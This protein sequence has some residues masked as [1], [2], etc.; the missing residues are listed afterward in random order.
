MR[1]IFFKEEQ[2]INQLWIWAVLIVSMGAMIVPTAIGFYKQFYL[3][4]P[5]GTNPTGDEALLWIGGLELVFAIG[6]I[7]L[8]IKMKLVTVVKE[9]GFYYRY[10][11]L[12]LK[13]KRI[14]KE[15]IER[16]EIRKYKPILEY[17]GWGVRLGS[18]KAGR[19][20]NVKGNIGLQ[21]ELKNGRKILFG[22]QRADALKRAMEK[23]MKEPG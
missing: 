18:R 17:G 13:E 7:V 2:Y 11:P 3:G 20:Y 19:A 9:D 1:R 6:L 22:T 15:E 4:K 23:M 16:F 21:L 14:G 12:I 10:P 5:W 8:I